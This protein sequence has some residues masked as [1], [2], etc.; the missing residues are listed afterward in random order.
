[1]WSYGS[2]FIPNRKSGIA[3]PNH[4]SGEAEP[5]SASQEA[6]QWK[7]LYVKGC[8]FLPKNSFK[9]HF[10]ICVRVEGM[11]LNFYLRRGN[12]REWESISSLVLS[13]SL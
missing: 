13:A 5:C 10:Y 3:S 2:C 9:F 11:T 8:S 1:M 6:S 12:Q 4:G 7:M